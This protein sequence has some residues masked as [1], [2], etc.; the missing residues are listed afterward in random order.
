M[1]AVQS[2]I[3]TVIAA[4]LE[5]KLTIEQ[6]SMLDTPPTTNPR[7]YEKLMLA[8]A[9]YAADQSAEAV[10]ALEAAVALDPDSA[11]LFAELS[12]L[13]SFRIPDEGRDPHQAAAK[14]ALDRAQELDGSRPEV[15]LALATYHYWVEQDNARA[16]EVALPALAKLPNE[17][18]GRIATGFLLKR[19]GRWQESQELFLRAVELDPRNR[20]AAK[21][22][23]GHAVALRDRA[24]LQRAIFLNAALD[25]AGEFPH[26]GTSW[27]GLEFDGD[28]KPRI[29]ALRAL[30]VELRQ[31]DWAIGSA[32]H[33]TLATGDF[34]AARDLLLR[35]PDADRPPDGHYE[36]MLGLALRG[37]GDTTGAREQFELALQ[38]AREGV[39]LSDPNYG[40]RR[41]APALA[42][43][44]YC[45]ALL[46][47][48]SVGV[49]DARRAAELLPFE[50]DATEGFVALFYLAATHAELGQADEAIAVLER[51]FSRPADLGPGFVWVSWKFASLR[52]NP[53][54][55]ALL[56]RQGV[57]VSNNPYEAAAEPGEFSGWLPGRS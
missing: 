52:D 3:A 44:G 12:A 6:R 45:E 21:Y 28:L 27:E 23:L 43:A 56:K 11:V 55:R 34:A 39:R 17:V 8:R 5:Q 49:E 37:A 2:E 19:L 35:L 40:V 22:L 20:I 30:P 13:H 46:G 53:R 25:P 15:Q 41:L 42:R 4:Q 57:N 29:A 48:G 50:Q 31:Q 51:L 36:E 54:F 33:A 10:A 1:F 7:A 9:L 26:L 18:T 47:N 38:K 32:I 16:I 14:A 24:A